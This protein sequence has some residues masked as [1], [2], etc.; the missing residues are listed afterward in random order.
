MT[1]E[2]LYSQDKTNQA[3]LKYKSYLATEDKTYETLA[4]FRLG[5]IYQAKQEWTQAD[6]YHLAFLQKADDAQQK[7]W[8]I[9]NL[10]NRIWQPNN[11]K[12]LSNILKIALK[13]QY[14]NDPHVIADLSQA[15]EKSGKVAEQKTFLKEAKDNQNISNKDRYAFQFNW[16]VLAFQKG[17][18]QELT[19]DLQNIPKEAKDEEKIYLIYIRG[20]CHFEQKNW[21]QAAIDLAKIPVASKFFPTAF[22]NLLEALRQ[23]NDGKSWNLF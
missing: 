8:C 20:M 3:I 12:N 9:A 4:Q 21:K 2:S 1:G 19:H 10:A 18:C 6:S 13:N 16:A 15:L 23:Q 17:S 7:I 11:M 5:E 14:Q 22:D